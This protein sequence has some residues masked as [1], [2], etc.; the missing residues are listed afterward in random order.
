VRSLLKQANGRPIVGLSRSPDKVQLGGIQVRPGE[1]SNRTQF[2]ASLKGVD[3]FV[4]VSLNTPPEMRTEQHRT[5]LAAAKDAGVR[6]IIYTSV[7][8]AEDGPTASPVIQSNRQTEADLRAGGFDWTV[9]RNGIYIEPDVEYIDSYKAAGEI[10]N[11]AG[12]GVCGYTTRS[13][14]AA[15][16]AN[17]ALDER[18]NGRIYYLHGTAMTQADL[19]S[20]L[21]TAFGTALRYRE[22]TVEDY[23]ADRRAALGDDMG[24]IIAGIYEGIRAG[25]FDV[26]SDFATAAGRPHQEWGDYFARLRAEQSQSAG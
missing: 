9:G 19:A 5:A 17:I 6:R 7:Q 22:M 13:E 26:P 2:T 23:R 16:Y 1:Y 24:P 12:S 10:A 15:A 8:G 11:S 21:N 14:L 18:H 25:V 20:Y 4:M 3:T